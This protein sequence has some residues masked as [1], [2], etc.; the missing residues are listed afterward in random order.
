MRIILV[1]V[2]SF[3]L[4]AC[5]AP[6]YVMSQSFDAE[7]H[8][9]AMRSGT[10]VLRGQA[11]LRTVGGEVRTCAGLRVNL[12]PATNY[13]VELATV[14]QSGLYSQIVNIDQRI[15]QYV[16]HTICG[17]DGSFT[18]RDLPPGDWIVQATVVWGVPV[19]SYRTV[20]QGGDVVGRATTRTDQTTEVVLTR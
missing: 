13:T 5:E 14:S 8:S 7:E 18:F 17:V 15:H 4:S 16:R 19:S 3:L 11:F 6:R 9:R 1:A 10:A 12:I 2:S 20:R